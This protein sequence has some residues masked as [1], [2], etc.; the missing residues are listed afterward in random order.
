MAKMTFAQENHVV[1]GLP[2][3]PDM[4]FREG[5]ALGSTG[6]GLDD[7]DAFGFYDRV[8]RLK[9]SVA[10]MDQVSALLRNIIQHHAE[11][12]GLLAGPLG[13][14]VGRASGDVDPSGTQMNVE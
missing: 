2:D 13:I 11:V 7:L 6:R 4:S 1:Q 5:V 9:G 3:F 8:E 10:I 12:P 14:G